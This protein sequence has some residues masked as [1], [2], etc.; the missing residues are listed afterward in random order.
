LT[1]FTISYYSVP[2]SDVPP[3]VEG[4]SAVPVSVDGSSVVVP[5]S[6][7]GSSVGAGAGSVVVVGADSVVVGAVCVGEVVGSAVVVVRAVVGSCWAVVRVGVAEE[8]ST[9]TSVYDVCVGLRTT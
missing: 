5:V 6:V 9:F 1:P 3:S 2:P 4:C 7:V 8:R